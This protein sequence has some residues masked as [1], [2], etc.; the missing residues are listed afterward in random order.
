MTSLN[1]TWEPKMIHGKENVRVR[2]YLNAAR[3]RAPFTWAAL[4]QRGEE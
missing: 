3:V 4:L 2:G 1:G